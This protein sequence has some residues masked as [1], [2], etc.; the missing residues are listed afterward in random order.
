M[1]FTGMLYTSLVYKHVIIIVMPYYEGEEAIDAY[2]AFLTSQSKYSRYSIVRNGTLF[3]CASFGGD[4]LYQQR[5]SNLNM[6]YISTR[7]ELENNLLKTSVFYCGHVNLEIWCL[8]REINQ[9]IHA[10]AFDRKKH[11]GV[12]PD[13]RKSQEAVSLW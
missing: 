11:R 10:Y 4:I 9:I 12:P 1:T 6:N 8:P 5:A 3:N 2:E 13:K 7:T